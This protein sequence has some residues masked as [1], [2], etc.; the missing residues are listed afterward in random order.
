MCCSQCSALVV[1]AVTWQDIPNTSLLG[2][3]SEFAFIRWLMVIH[4][5]WQVVRIGVVRWLRGWGSKGEQVFTMWT[6]V[7]RGC[8]RE[9]F[10]HFYVWCILSLFGNCA[11]FSSS[12][13]NHA[14]FRIPISLSIYNKT[15]MLNVLYVLRKRFPVRFFILQSHPFV[16]FVITFFSWHYIITGINKQTVKKISSCKTP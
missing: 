9:S 1:I 15:W 14:S 16:A 7:L 4:V 11:I 2:G 8:R 10:G 6:G 12:L 5:H 13:E 3:W